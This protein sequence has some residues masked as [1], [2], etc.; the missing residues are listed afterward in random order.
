VIRGGAVSVRLPPDGTSIAAELLR[1][2]G[3]TV[4]VTVGFK[5]FPGGETSMGSY[6]SDQ[7]RESAGALPGT[8]ISFEPAEITLHRGGMGHGKVLVRNTGAGRLEG[9]VDGG[10][11]WLRN[12]GTAAVV[13][14]YYGTLTGVGHRLSLSPGEGMSIGFITGT[15]SC[16]PGADY[17]VPVG[18]Y[19]LVV[20]LS[21]ELA[22]DNEKIQL[23]AEGGFAV[24]H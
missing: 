17:V 1:E 4:E 20:P 15:A 14:G 6:L 10:P 21:V 13:G 19:E 22:G 5:A 3:N 16:Q 7:L 18:R 2:F 24:V 23:T 11:G 12:P 8:Q 9:L